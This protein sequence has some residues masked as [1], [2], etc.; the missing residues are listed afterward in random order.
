M[1]LVANGWL[2]R[3][4]YK[5]KIYEFAGGYASQTSAIQ[6]EMWDAIASY[7]WKSVAFLGGDFNNAPL[8]KDNTTGRSHMLHIQKTKWAHL[9]AHTQARDPWLTLEFNML[10]FTYH[11]IAF[12]NY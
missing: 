7:P 3:H 8:P 2:C 5:G 12:H 11:H 9:I 6:A 10:G 1:I 4:A